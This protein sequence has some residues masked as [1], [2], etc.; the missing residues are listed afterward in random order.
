MKL[1]TLNTHSWLEKEQERKI[2]EIV[3][4]IKK[5]RVEI[6][7]MQEVNQL[8]SS[9]KIKGEI[10]KDNFLF[11]LKEKLGDD[12]NFVWDYHHV[13]YDIYNE[14]TGV[15][16]KGEIEEHCSEFLGDI[17]DHN[18]WKT[19]KFSMVSKKI[20]DKKIDF[21]SCHMGWWKDEESSFERQ[22]DDILKFAKKR[23]NRFF[24]MGDFNNSA[25]IKGEGYDYLL[26]KGLY[27]TYHLAQIKDDGI[28]VPGEIAGWEGKSKLPKRID[29]IF[30]SEKIDVK[31]SEVVF[32]GKKYEVVSDHFGVLI[33]I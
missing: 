19:R 28:T 2:D 24:L 1:L 16:F 14:G 5:E 31:S 20:G 6:I 18:Y 15:L 13:G 22:I 17:K 12:Y 21:Y 25:D 27:D 3:N 26:E 30:S 7:A 33:E 29:Y 9:E 32:N 23:G 4:M 10:K 11:V 8:D